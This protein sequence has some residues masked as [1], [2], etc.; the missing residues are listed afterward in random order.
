MNEE[1]VRRIIIGIF[2]LRG[3]MQNKQQTN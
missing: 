1:F 2:L 3:I